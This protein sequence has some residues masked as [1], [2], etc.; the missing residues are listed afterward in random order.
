MPART[1]LRLTALALTLS[2]ALGASAQVADARMPRGNASG[3][4]IEAPAGYQPQFLCKKTMQPGVRAFRSLVLKQY[5]ST[6]SASD[7]RACSST[8][9]S[10]HA[11]GRA[12]DWGVRVSKKGERKKAEAVLGWLLARDEFGNDFA[13]ARRLGIMYIIWN[14]QMWRSYSGEWGPYSCSGVTSCH[15]DHIHFSFGWAGAYKKTSFWTGNVA[16]QMGPPLPLYDSL[17][18]P[19]RVTVKANEGQ[20]YGGKNL[21]GGLLY[22]V[23]ASGTYKY[24]TQ[25][26][27]QADAACRMN[28][29]GQWVQDRN[30][31]IS[32]VWNLVPTVP[33]LTGCNT[34]NHSYIA[35][36]TPDITDAVSFAISDDKLK[37]NSGSLDVAIRRVLALPDLGLGN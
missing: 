11:D 1:A 7:V 20:K 34:V 23:N 36:M 22:T 18:N 10:E 21:G 4:A 6:H 8:H 24:G 9:T 12:W 3:P 32:G 27:H 28:K 26:F 29:N 30:L 35:T 19:W 13:M 14:K 5:K 16:Q 31:R 33:S 15:Q 2:T 25:D 17:T 37:D